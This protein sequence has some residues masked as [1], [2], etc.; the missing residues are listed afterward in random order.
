MEQFAN[1]LTFYERL[2]GVVGEDSVRK[3]ELMSGHTTFRIGG[4]ADFYVEPKGEQELLGL[5]TMCRQESVPFFIV[6]KGSNLL[7]SDEGIE[8]V[9]IAVSSKM[10]EL[11]ITELENTPGT[12]EVEAYAGI[13][14]TKLASQ[15]AQ[16]SITGFEFASGIPG[17]LGGAVY[18][19]AGAYGGEI[20][21]VLVSARIITKEGEI[22]SMSREELELSY[23]YSSLMETEGIV[24]SAKLH[25]QAGEKE[26]I[27]KQM[28][29]L[30]AKRVEKQPLEFP[31][32]GSTFKRPEG[33]FA[34]KLIMDAGLRGFRVGDAM[35]SEKHCGFVVNAGSATATQVKTLMEEVSK[36]VQESFGVALEP[37]VRMVGRW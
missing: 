37:E 9:V 32:A 10:E 7:V 1:D 4:P 2:V 14:L 34:G 36:R 23:R 35:V 30:A 22:V 24:L 8:G 16:K 13:S 27:L 19:N 20:K 28:K 11:S 5:L 12:Y 15:L 6:G 31:S 33:H 25:F 3:Q 29:E 18:M 26:E 17:T 21:D